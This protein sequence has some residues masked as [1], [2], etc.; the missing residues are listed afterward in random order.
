MVRV[1]DVRRQCKD[2]WRL[3]RRAIWSLWQIQCRV[4]FDFVAHWNLD[5]PAQVVVR[6]WLCRGWRRSWGLRDDVYCE[7]HAQGSREE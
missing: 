2:Y 1:R 7:T 3:R 6:R 4:Q 5:T